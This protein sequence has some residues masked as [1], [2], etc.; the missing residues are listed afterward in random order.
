MAADVAL[1]TEVERRLSPLSRI[2]RA[3][4]ARSRLSSCSRHAEIGAGEGNRTL[5]FSLEGCCS[6][7]ELHPPGAPRAEGL[8]HRPPRSVNGQ[9]PAVVTSTMPDA[10]IEA[11]TS[12]ISTGHEIPGLPCGRQSLARSDNSARRWSVLT[13]PAASAWSSSSFSLPSRSSEI[14]LDG[15]SGLGLPQPALDLLLDFLLPARRRSVRR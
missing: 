6:T 14:A 13:E 5:V 9:L 4:K 12:R 11:I 2:R 1:S 7:I 10:M 8:C 15:P 3:R